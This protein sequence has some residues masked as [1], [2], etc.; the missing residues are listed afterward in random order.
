MEPA[1]NTKD[2]KTLAK[3]AILIAIV[4]IAVGLKAFVSKKP[5][6]DI[7]PAYASTPT[8]SPASSSSAANTS[9][10]SSNSTGANTS[11]AY[12][13]GN[14][15]ATGQYDSPG[16]NESIT[17]SLSLKNG[18]VTATSAKSGANDSTAQQFQSDFIAGYKSLVVGKSIDSIHLSRVSGSS[19][20]SQGFNEA[21]NSIKSQAKA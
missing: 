1:N 10:A 15:S 14:Y 13:D 4:I 7:I 17:I 9:G 19:L 21:L 3:L 12:K 11:S 8:G 6:M 5:A 2:N 16:G 20:T 18:D